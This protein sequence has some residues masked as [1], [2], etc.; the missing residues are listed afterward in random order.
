MTNDISSDERQILDNLGFGSF[1]DDGVISRAE[2]NQMKALKKMIPMMRLE[3]NKA[4]RAGVDVGESL[5]E[6]T[7]TES[8]I[9]K[10][11]KIYD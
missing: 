9:E 11:L 4:Q 10:L 1:L 2:I 3:Y 8:E 7:Q 5:R 6:L